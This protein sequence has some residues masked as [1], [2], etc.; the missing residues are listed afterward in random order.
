MSNDNNFSFAQNRIWILEK[1]AVQT[2]ANTINHSLQL[3]GTVDIHRL[4][5]AIN[6]IIC[7]HDTLRAYV[8]EE[9][10]QPQF[11]ISEEVVLTIE[12]K[13]I[14]SDQN[15][16]SNIIAKYAKESIDPALAPLL[17]AIYYRLDNDKHLLILLFHHLIID[18]W[19]LAIF[20]KKLQH[21][22]ADL[23]A[24]NICIPAIQYKD[25]VHWQQQCM[26]TKKM[27][28]QI[29]YWKKQLDNLPQSLALPYDFSRERKISL[30]G[31]M[32]H[33]R[34]DSTIR[35]NILQLSEQVNVTPNQIL[36]SCFAL[37]LKKL[38]Q[39]DDIV[40]GTV[41]ANRNQPALENLIGLCINSI[42]LRIKI[43]LTQSLQDFMASQKNVVSMA[44]KNSD[45]P[46]DLLCNEIAC[47]RDI[48][49]HPIFQVLFVF[50]QNAQGQ[51]DYHLDNLYIDA[52]DIP[53]QHTL[54]DL[55]LII[56][57][58]PTDIHVT[59]HYSDTLFTEKSIV[60]FSDLFRR[61]LNHILNDDL[62]ATLADMQLSSP[63]AQIIKSS[64]TL[65]KQ[66][67]PLF[68]RLWKKQR[69]QAKHPAIIC[70]QIIIDYKTLAN[71]TTAMMQYFKTLGIE[72]GDRI[73]LLQNRSPELLYS[74]L[75]A[76]EM[77]ITFIPVDPH[78]PQERIAC[79][80]S[81]SKAKAVILSEDKL[82]QND[83]DISIPCYTNKPQQPVYHETK[84]VHPTIT[85]STA[86]MIYTSGSTGTPKGVCI[87]RQSLSNLLLSMEQQ[88]G[89]GQQDYLLA[90]TTIGFDIALLELLLPLMTGGT[91]VLATDEQRSDPEQIHRLLDNW[92]ISVMQATP[93]FWQMLFSSKNKAYPKLAIWCGGEKLSF[94]LAQQLLNNGQQLW[95]L[96]GPTETTIWSCANSIKAG[97]PICIANPVAN[98]Q[99]VVLDENQVPVA[100]NCIGE[101]YIAG[102]GLAE[103]YW[104][105]R[106]MTQGKFITIDL[107]QE[108]KCWYATGDL[109]KKLSNNTYIYQCRKDFQVKIRGYRIELGEIENRINQFSGVTQSVI[110]C[111]LA[112]NGEDTLVAYIQCDSNTQ[113]TST[114]INELRAFCASYLPSY[115]I[116]QHFEILVSFPR[117]DNHKIAVN[118]LP[119]PNWQ[120]QPHS[121]QATKCLSKLEKTLLNIWRKIF[122]RT[123]LDSFNNFF[124]LG[125]QSIIATQIISEI[126]RQCQIDLPLSRLFEYPSVAELAEYCETLN[127]NPSSRSIDISPPNEEMVVTSAPLSSAQKALWLQNNLADIKNIYHVGF[128]VDIS[129]SFDIEKFKLAL[130]SIVQHQDI[131]KVSIAESCDKPI[132]RIQALEKLPLTSVCLKVN[133]NENTIASM[134]KKLMEKPFDLV[135]E[136]LWRIAVLHLA[137]DKTQLIFVFHHLI[138]DGWSLHL[139][140]QQLSAYYNSGKLESD[141]ANT[142]ISYL[143]FCHWH[144]KFLKQP[145][146]SKQKEY[147]QQQLAQIPPQLVFPIA[148]PRK[149]WLDYHGKT[150][151]RV[152]PTSL[153]SRLKV[154]ANQQQVSFFNLLFA[155][156]GITIYRFTRQ[157]TF[158]IGVPVSQRHYPKVK[159][160]LGFFLNTLPIVSQI[161]ESLSLNDYLSQVKKHLLDGFSNQD[162]PLADLIT[163]SQH[164]RDPSFHPLFQVLFI[165]DEIPTP[166]FSFVNTD[167]HYSL[168]KQAISHYDLTF[169]IH[170]KSHVECRIKYATAL[171]D[172]KFIENFLTV[173]QTLCQ[174]ILHHADPKIA[175]LPIISRQQRSH[176]LSK[177]LGKIDLTEPKTLFNNYFDHILK[178]HKSNVALCDGNSVLTYKELAIQSTELANYLHQQ[179]IK[180]QDRIIVM[181]PRQC[182][183][184]ITVLA[185]FKLGAV[186]IP[187]DPNTPLHR[188]QAVI[189]QIK[190]H[191][192]ILLTSTHDTVSI[193]P[194][195]EKLFFF[196]KVKF[197]QSGSNKQNLHHDNLTFNDLAYII[198]TSGSTGV[199]KGVMV[200]HQGMMNHLLAKIQDMQLTATDKIAQVASQMFDI[201]IWQLLVAFVCGGTTIIFNE[202]AAFDPLA[203]LDCITK[204]KVTILELVP[205]HL[206]LILDEIDSNPQSEENLVTLRYLL[207]TGETFASV[208]CQRWLDKFPNIP[209]INAYGPTE[210]SDDVSHRLVKHSCDFESQTVPINGTILNTQLYVL[211]K[212]LNP[213][214][215]GMPGELCVTG[216][217]VGPGY[218]QA[219]DKTK[220]AFLLNAFSPGLSNHLYRTGDL[221]MVR[222]HSIEC[223]GR[224]DHQIKIRGY[225][226][227]ISEIESVLCQHNLIKQALV[228]HSKAKDNDVLIAYILSD[229]PAIATDVK[230]YLRDKLPYY[231]IPDVILVLDQF[232]LLSSGKIDRANLPKYNPKTAKIQI[233]SDMTRD[234]RRLVLLWKEVLQHDEFDIHQPFY[235]AGGSSLNLLTL[236]IAIRREFDKPISAIDLLQ[237]QTIEE[238]ACLLSQKQNKNPTIAMKCFSNDQNQ[239]PLYCIHPITG[240]AECYRF[241][242]NLLPEFTV[243]GISNPYF[244]QPLRDDYTT[245][246]QMATYYRQHFIRMSDEYPL[247]L[248]GWS[249]GG[250]VA[251]EVACQLQKLTH[252]P[253]NLILIDS[254]NLAVYNTPVI[255]YNVSEQ[256]AK[257]QNI[258]LD[259]PKIQQ[260]QQ[261][262]HQ[263]GIRLQSF[264]PEIFDGD[265]HLIQ[266]TE[267]E[268]HDLEYKK[269]Y[270]YGWQTQLTGNI[271]FSKI[272]AQHTTILDPRFHERLAAVIKNLLVETVT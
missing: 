199:P 171:F 204:E 190:P 149:K 208:L 86:Y 219:A 264:K 61:I 133:S 174:S 226:V 150:V 265:I 181:L 259:D 76:W 206:R 245:L 10:V 3:T 50:H 106:E 53:E 117:T 189:E 164:R 112:P 244:C 109:V 238:Q 182:A 2:T 194:K 124:E 184:A 37:L 102:V 85:N 115:M 14:N 247:F 54:L 168:I 88:P 210:C 81:D 229:E 179:G 58:N 153:V 16:T 75:A 225:R 87:S 6:R 101:L 94:K 144:D 40:I 237:A 128:T 47:N 46:F 176:L 266:A 205:S 92:P 271:H 5:Q 200:H 193:N 105:L 17:R 141:Q 107:N 217:G 223:L 26:P 97:E 96:Y 269:K 195:K 99:L 23:H 125:G 180:H 129:G 142:T 132:Q 203:L 69:V 56:K 123:N 30:T 80:L 12:R 216:K 103:G 202:N 224:F 235:Q 236:A 154:F 62:N 49:I 38:S 25:F 59:W 108:H 175:D 188:Q 27:Q 57:L 31:K 166:N 131:L 51:Q 173:F 120:Q 84:L 122:C 152:L 267:I 158:T 48:N 234:K 270:D 73:V 126:S 253:I 15:N 167:T 251:F 214:P 29:N 241:L 220:E 221:V 119:I 63:S 60:E 42:P 143:Q 111:Q 24:P 262:I 155:L 148:K 19:S 209:I 98:T 18:G 68:Y 9:N 145:L 157:K 35:K 4:E 258:P 41:F 39:Q 74:L 113:A 246:K 65:P 250:N 222:D 136:P 239:A 134:K 79:I 127:S 162:V 159:N 196:D 147:W 138:T 191:G 140:A 170:E 55:T 33:Q 231:M 232:P 135:N 151:S 156:F 137:T 110:K 13:L 118:K 1:L 227:E 72:Q 139:F 77:G 28:H 261:E 83:W 163:L 93:S 89:F 8:N 114:W 90:V 201:S 257:Q 218:W 178:R 78:M 243:F 240:L 52:V 186:Y 7:E 95:N 43:D 22:Y 230:L 64:I 192:I 233:T 185:L 44:Q 130:K 255:K 45:V 116:P 20:R 146:L 71:H 36:L 252:T 198:F 183:W 272:P 121:T 254:Y 11:I 213:V 207:V 249:F 21:Y 212:S 211:D 256:I 34:I 187:L 172:Q 70:S 165:M 169:H 104:Q 100:D 248:L 91:L 160:T 228:L 32:L 197:A 177:W 67:K 263:N 260:I 161:N 66:V 242:A 215:D 268:N 82:N